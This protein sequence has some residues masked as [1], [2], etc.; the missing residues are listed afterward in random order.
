MISA[1]DRQKMPPHVVDAYPLTAMQAGMVFQSDLQRGDAL[2][3]AVNSFHL[4]VRFDRDALQ[5]ALQQFAELYEV[6][7]ISFDLANFSE[8]LQLV[9]DTVQVPL[10][11]DDLRGLAASEQEKAIAGWLKVDRYTRLDLTHAPLLRFHVHRRTNESLQFTFTAHHAIFDGWSDAV[12]LTELL[13]LYLEILEKGSV[14]ASPLA[15]S[16]RDYVALEKEALTS[17]ESQQFWLD[18]LSDADTTKAPSWS[19]SPVDK[20]TQRFDSSHIQFAAELGHRLNDLARSRSVTLK[21]I[22]LAA[23]LHICALLSGRKDVVT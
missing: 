9:H 17:E 21:S 8:P 23:H 19:N 22:L 13:K 14:I 2:Y 11:V 4:R 15:V 12:F 7:R 10:G 1:E 6:M 5:R 20:I 3:H 16:F 18:W